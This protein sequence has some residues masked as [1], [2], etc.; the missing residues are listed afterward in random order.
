[1]KA[2]PKRITNRERLEELQAFIKLCFL[3]IDEDDINQ[4]SNRTGLC[5]STLYRIQSSKLTT[6]IQ[7]GT[8]Q[9]LSEAA[10]LTLIKVDG[11]YRVKAA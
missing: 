11:R 2:K 6:R 7:V 9:R 5:P 8:L 10:G 4:I 1:M 3:T